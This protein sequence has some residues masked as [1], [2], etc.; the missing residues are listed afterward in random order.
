M[1]HKQDFYSSDDI[2]S[3]S[4]ERLRPFKLEKPSLSSPPHE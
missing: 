1:T 4:N 3:D 2:S